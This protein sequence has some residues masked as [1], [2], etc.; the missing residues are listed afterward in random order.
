VFV[1]KAQSVLIDGEVVI[2]SDNGMLD[3]RAP[4]SKRR[5][6]EA[7]LYAFDLIEH[8]GIDLRDLPLVRS[9]RCRVEQPTD[10]THDSRKSPF[11]LLDTQFAAVE[12]RIE[13]QIG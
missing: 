9:L 8:D 12:L 6:H 13:S 11:S 10:P 3:F 4:Q 7:V 5:G 2:T 1:V